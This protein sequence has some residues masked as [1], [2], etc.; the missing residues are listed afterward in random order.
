MVIGGTLTLLPLQIASAQT[1][2]FFD[3]PA[4]H[5]AF[6]SVE[7]LKQK[8][9]LGGYPDGTF[10]PDKRVN[11]AESLKII[12]AQMMSEKEKLATAS[13]GFSDVKV[14]AWF[15][16]YLVFAKNRGNIVN[17]PP[18]AP[19]FNPDRTV[20]KGEFLKMLFM[21]YKVDPQS[22]GD[23]KLPLSSDVTNI[24]EWYYPHLRYALSANVTAV[25]QSGL[26]SPGRD[27]TRGDVAVLMHRFLLYRNG[28]RIS[29]LLTE[30]RRNIVWVMDAL[31]KSDIREAEYASARAV[32]AARGAHA[33][34]DN[35]E[36]KVAVKTAESVRALVRAYRAGID[37]DIDQVIKLSQDAWFLAD[38][39]RTINP[40]V[41]ELAAQLQS[42]AKDFAESAR[43]QKAKK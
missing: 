40:N 31:E 41:S 27:L 38:Q 24:N 25:S 2:S 14:D 20:T 26:L 36:T 39:A 19:T 21:A 42:Y 3:V 15:V 18:N 33:S 10:G 23:V 35:V 4:D 37:G 17:F 34:Q 7:Y 28:E 11:R 43:Q 16:P 6:E 5:F 30:A 13:L 29:S 32:L 22:F 8:K 1:P 12:T 9:I